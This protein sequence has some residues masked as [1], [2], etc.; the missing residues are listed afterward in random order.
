MVRWG[1]WMRSSVMVCRLREM[2]DRSR[3]L[4]WRHP[5]SRRVEICWAVLLMAVRYLTPRSVRLQGPR[6]LN[7]SREGQHWLTTLRML[8]FTRLPRFRVRR[9]RR[10]RRHSLMM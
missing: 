7:S 5:V 10:L 1:R 9:L 2:S 3:T 8:L 6:H 4:S